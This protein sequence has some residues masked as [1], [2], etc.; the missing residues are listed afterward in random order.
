MN[1]LRTMELI[2]LPVENIGQLSIRNFC[3]NEAPKEG[4]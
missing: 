1:R 3:A 4:T 2:Q